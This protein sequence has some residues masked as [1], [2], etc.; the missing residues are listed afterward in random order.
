MPLL[1][2]LRVRC[3]GCEL[4]QHVKLNYVVV[5]EEYMRLACMDVT[6]CKVSFKNVLGQ[7]IR[8]INICG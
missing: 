4:C 1:D 3:T 2:V 7:N 6:A 5:K 8:S